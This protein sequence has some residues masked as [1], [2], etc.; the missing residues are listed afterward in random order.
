LYRLAELDRK[1]SKLEE[2]EGSLRE[3]IAIDP[4][5][6]SYHALLAQVLKQQ[7][8]EQESAEQMKLEARLK[9]QFIR[10]HAASKCLLAPATSMV[11]PTEVQ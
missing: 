11:R 4:N 3:A 1:Y 7:G 9:E 8:R 10:Q 6:A 5:A 2:A